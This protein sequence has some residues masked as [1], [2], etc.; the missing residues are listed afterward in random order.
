[1]KKEQLM[2]CFL[3]TLVGCKIIIQRKRTRYKLFLNK[4]TLDHD[5]KKAIFYD[6]VI[7][8]VKFGALDC[9]AL[10]KRETLL[11]KLL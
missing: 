10:V 4:K 2:L 7:K 6:A 1:V 5:D 3:L 8:N 11:H 9:V